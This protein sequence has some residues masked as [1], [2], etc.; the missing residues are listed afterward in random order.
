MNLGWDLTS[1]WPYF[2]LLP[3]NQ[4]HRLLVVVQWLS[5]ALLCDP[6]TAARQVALSFTISQCLL[7]LR[8]IESV[9]LSTVSFSATPFS[10]CL[11]SF[12]ASGFFPM[13]WLFTS[14][15]QNIGASA[16]KTVV[17]MNIQDFIS[18]SMYQLSHLYMTTGRTIALTIQTDYLAITNEWTHLGTSTEKLFNNTK[19][20]SLGRRGDSSAASTLWCPGQVN[21]GLLVLL[22][23]PVEG[24]VMLTS[25]GHAED[26]SCGERPSTRH[27]CNEWEVLSSLPFIWETSVKASPPERAVFFFLRWV[28]P[29]GLCSERKTNP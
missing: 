27:V 24:L 6:T 13:S 4:R 5:H 17:P 20:I 25:Q 12:P 15:G 23:F 14:G 10:F 26:T 16:S 8:S 3:S 7:K 22:S 19:S 1:S 28:V 2:S 18:F 9:M 29:G 11:Q 21:R